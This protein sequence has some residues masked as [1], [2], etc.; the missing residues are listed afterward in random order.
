MTYILVY[1]IDSALLLAESGLY[2]LKISADFGKQRRWYKN[3]NAS[4]TTK[5]KIQTECHIIDFYVV[6]AL[7]SS[8]KA[9]FFGVLNKIKIMV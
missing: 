2:I 9:P 3:Q 8:H 6:Q 5:T 4:I 7:E 1:V